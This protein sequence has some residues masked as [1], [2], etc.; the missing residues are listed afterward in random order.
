MQERQYDLAIIGAGAGGLIAADFAVRLGARTALVEKDRIGGD[1][2]WTGCVPSKTLLKI[3]KI[4]HHLR[5]ASR[6]GIKSAS[7]SIDMVKVHDYVQ[8]TV[9]QIYKGT[10]PEALRAK[11]ID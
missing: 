8:A 3:A 10:T 6:Y 2:T 1:C 7:P 9:Q 5:S 11:G 4:A